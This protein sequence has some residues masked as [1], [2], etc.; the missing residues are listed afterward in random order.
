[1]TLTL[2]VPPAG[3]ETGTLV[4]PLTENDC[5]VTL[6]CVTLTAAEL[7]FA[8]D[9]VALVALPTGML[10]RFT[11]A[12]D[13]TRLIV[14]AAFTTVPLHP[15]RNTQIEPASA[16]INRVARW[17]SMIRASPCRETRRS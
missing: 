4:C 5:P 11:E 6:I 17:P 9:T 16:A 7:L 13:A 12:G 1:M 8:T 2:S 10:P 3:I 15:V 14:S